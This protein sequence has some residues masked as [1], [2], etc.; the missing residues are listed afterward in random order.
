ML[1]A[2]SITPRLTTRRRPGPGWVPKQHGAWAMLVVPVLVGA[3]LG[4]AQWVHLLL[5]AAWLAG[6]LFFQAAGTWLRS[7]R[8]ARYRPPVLAYGAATVALGVPLLVLRPALVRWAPLFAVLLALS[9][10]ASVRRADRS[11]W[12]DAVTVLAAAAMTPVA[13]GLGA[14]VPA[15]VWWA[16]A[17]LLAYLGG[18]VPYVK[19]MIRERGNRRV[20]AFSVAYHVVTALAGAWVHPLWGVVGMLLAVR[21]LVVPLRWPRASVR[22][23]GLGEV[24]ATLVVTAAV[25]VM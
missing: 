25:L 17:A 11:W 1:I 2:A 15:R 23:V 6:Y 4:G 21:A 13:A 5:L 24:A 14:G 8:R 22:A 18:T 19:T 9:L 7:R 16:G 10:A 20:L 3:V 12:N